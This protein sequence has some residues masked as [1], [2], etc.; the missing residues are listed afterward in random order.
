MQN[1]Q[2]QFVPNYILLKF[3]AIQTSQRTYLKEKTAFQSFPVI[4]GDT[5]QY[6][7]LSRKTF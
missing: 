1:F 4:L 5:D 2:K 7:D 3:A 6:E